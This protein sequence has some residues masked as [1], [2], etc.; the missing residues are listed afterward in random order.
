[1]CA[2]RKPIAMASTAPAAESL[3]RR[4]RSSDSRVVPEEFSACSLIWFRHR[5]SGHKLLSDRIGAVAGD[6]RDATRG[7]PR[8]TAGGGNRWRCR[9]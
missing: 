2:T 8:E 1:M 7:G 3:Q 5:P 9:I 6:P 4:R